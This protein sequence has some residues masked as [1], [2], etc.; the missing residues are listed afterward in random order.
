MS[1]EAKR[2]KCADRYVIVKCCLVISVVVEVSDFT[3]EGII[4]VSCL[5]VLG[6]K[7]VSGEGEGEMVCR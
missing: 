7:K 5:N 4:C 2:E 6:E 1:F 3:L